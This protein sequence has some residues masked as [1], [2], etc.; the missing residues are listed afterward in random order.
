MGTT[1]PTMIFILS[2]LSSPP[3]PPPLPDAADEAVLVDETEET[4]SVPVCV[5]LLD[6]ELG[7]EFMF[8]N[9]SDGGQDVVARAPIMMNRLVAAVMKIHSLELGEDT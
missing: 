9:G 2:D 8:D 4:V 1:V 3:P 7:S 5:E 6:G